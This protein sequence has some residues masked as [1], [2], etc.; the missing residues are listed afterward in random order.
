MFFYNWVHVDKIISSLLVIFSSHCIELVKVCKRSSSI[1]GFKLTLLLSLVEET[2][3]DS[4]ISGNVSV[5]SRMTSNYV[6][7]FR[8]PT[9]LQN[10]LVVN[11]KSLHMTE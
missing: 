3:K 10:L 5:S 1:V 2:N 7:S 11:S 4:N 9:F 6:F 8:I